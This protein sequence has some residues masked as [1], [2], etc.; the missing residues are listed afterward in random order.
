V[1]AGCE[2]KLPDPFK[3]IPLVDYPWNGKVAPDGGSAAW[4]KLD[5]KIRVHNLARKVALIAHKDARRQMVMDLA[6]HHAPEFIERFKRLVAW[7][8]RRQR[9]LQQQSKTK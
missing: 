6:Q 3:T 4:I 2:V 9:R 8:W 7:Y 5:G 1:G